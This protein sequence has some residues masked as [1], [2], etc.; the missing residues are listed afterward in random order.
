LTRG[1]SGRLTAA[2]LAGLF[3][4]ALI[5][6][7]PARAQAA[8]TDLRNAKGEAVSTATLTDDP[9]GVRIVLPLAKL[10]PGPH[11]F[12]VHAIGRCDQPRKGPRRVSDLPL[13]LADR[14]NEPAGIGA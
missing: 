13:E 1:T 2:L 14:V 12:H 3:L 8:R 9:D 4:L 10:L 5:M 7:A 11:G 6:P